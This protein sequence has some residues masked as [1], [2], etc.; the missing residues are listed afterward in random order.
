MIYTSTPKIRVM[1]AAIPR[2][3]KLVRQSS[4]E[5]IFRDGLFGEGWIRH[6]EF[7]AARVVYFYA[8]I[9]FVLDEMS[10]RP[11]LISRSSPAPFPESR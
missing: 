1:F 10:G 7:R 3:L 8:R 5:D 9:P 2:Q 11:E 6:F 4:S